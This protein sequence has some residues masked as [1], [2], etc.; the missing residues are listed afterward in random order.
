MFVVSFWA[1]CGWGGSDGPI[2]SVPTDPVVDLAGEGPVKTTMVWS[3]LAE[4]FPTAPGMVRPLS[5]ITPGMPADDARGSMA[6]SSKEGATVEA[7]EL[8]GHP[9]LSTTLRH[10]GTDVPVTVVLDPSGA[11][12]VSVDLDIEWPAAS[13]VLVER[14]GDPSPGAPLVDGRVL[15]RWKASPWSVEL[16][17]LSEGDGIL[18]YGAATDDG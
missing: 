10:G 2:R 5:A 18:H 14:W 7:S 11:T 3:D 13:S 9:T 16:H 8:G 1:A 15:A 17:R 12:V 6:A 4:M